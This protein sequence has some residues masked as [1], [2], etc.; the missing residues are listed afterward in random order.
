MRSLVSKFRRLLRGNVRYINIDSVQRR[1]PPQNRKQ[2]HLRDYVRPAFGETEFDLSQFLDYSGKVDGFAEDILIFFVSVTVNRCRLGVR[3]ATESPG[4]ITGSFPVKRIS[5]A[6]RLRG[7]EPKRVFSPLA[8]LNP[9]LRNNLEAH[10]E[11]RLCVPRSITMA[12][13]FS[14]GV[15]HKHPNCGIL[16]YAFRDEPTGH[17]SADLCDPSSLSSSLP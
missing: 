8:P 16:Y 4:K 2:M 1:N 9:K 13:T 15:P 10:G 11:T 5:A 3:R 17:S 7:D 12:T 14:V 6:L